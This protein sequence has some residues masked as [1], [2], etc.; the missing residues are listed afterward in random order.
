MRTGERGG[1]VVIGIDVSKK[2]LEVGVLPCEESWSA[3]Q[4]LVEVE[5]LADRIAALKP[6]LVVCEATGG[7]E[8]GIV[9]ALVE[10]TCMRP[11][12]SPLYLEKQI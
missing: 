10:P 3:G 11:R 7:L 8:L 2:S 5:A 12:S 1:P 4:T 6:E 9:H